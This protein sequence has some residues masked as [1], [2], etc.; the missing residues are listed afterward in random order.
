MVAA[1]AAHRH[2]LLDLIAKIWKLVRQSK[3]LQ[4]KMPAKESATWLAIINQEEALYR[5]LHPESC[6]LV[7]STAGSGSFAISDSNE[8]DVEGVENDPNVV[9]ECKPHDV[10]LFNL[11]MGSAKDGLM[12][13]LLLCIVRK[14]MNSIGLW[15]C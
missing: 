7:S 5:K 6:P 12:V 4:D 15:S 11:G 1:I 3:C 13:P 8:Y 2:T 9:Q 14:K 10:N